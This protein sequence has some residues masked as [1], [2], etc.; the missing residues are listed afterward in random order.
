MIFDMVLIKLRAFLYIILVLGSKCYKK[1]KS[2]HLFKSIN[3]MFPLFLGISI[4]ER[5]LQVGSEL[6][7]E[8]VRRLTQLKQFINIRRFSEYPRT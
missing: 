6:R 4:L 5:Q 3:L 1:E 2:L 7:G 8:K